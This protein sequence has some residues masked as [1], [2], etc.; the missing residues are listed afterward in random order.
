MISQSTSL[1]KKLQKQFS[2]RINLDLS[3]INKVIAK[4]NYPHLDLNNPIN[5]IG[6]DGKMSVLTSLKYFLEADNK[7]ITAFTSPH[8]YDFR[9]RFWLKNRYISINKIN[10]FIKIIKKIKIKLTL[11]ELLT[12]I[13]ILAARKQKN[14]S[15]NLVESGLLFRKDSTNLWNSP[16][17]Q[18]ITNINFQHKEW[19]NPKTL[20]EICRQKVG[21]LSKNTNIYI[22]KQNPATL[23]IIKKNLESNP[24]NKIYPS[25]WRL[26]KSKNQYFYKDKK[27]LIPIKTNFIN[28][29]GLINNL[30]LSI[31]VALDLGVKKKTIIKT[32]PKIKFE[33][34]LQYIK[35]GK[36][37]KYV[38]MND[39]IL[40]DGCHS[41]TSGKNLNNY[42]KS[43][44]GPIYGIWGMQKNKMPGEFIKIFQ[45]T[46]KK[47]ITITIPNEPNALS[48]KELKKL[49]T[50]KNTFYVDNI[51]EA[52]NTLSSKEKKTI[53]VFGSMYL[54]GDVLSKN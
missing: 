26:K 45:R 48:G 38:N 8:L 2:R 54:I 42:L 15:Y 33:G 31:K 50:I 41:N 32:I 1:Y 16:R 17:A 37:R 49:S 43:L 18:I 5:I 47:L 40:I 27:N 25:Q 11:F 13:Y 44:K 10:Y 46:F 30:C 4:L 12:C 9:H 20:N 35:Y 24:S 6:S 23:R 3:R 14:I 28:S 51:Y 21:Y 7:S 29:N 53:V 52:L 22:A 19:I 36:L 39:N 34:R